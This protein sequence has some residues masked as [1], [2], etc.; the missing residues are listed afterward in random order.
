MENLYILFKNCDMR[1]IDEFFNN[2]R[3]LKDELLKY[4]FAKNDNKYSYEQNIVGDKFKV[5]IVVGEQSVMISII[6]TKTG[7]EYQI[8]FIVEASGEFVGEVRKEYE[9]LLS[10]I[11]YKCTEINVFQT[12]L[13]FDILKY[14][15][16]KYLV[17]PEFLWKKIPSGAVLRKPSSKKWFGL[18]MKINS[19]SIGILKP[20]IIE[21]LNVKLA[22]SQINALIDYQKFFPAYHMNKKSWITICCN[23]CDNI[24]NI[25]ELIDISYSLV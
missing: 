3:F 4:G 16:E 10:D 14:C 2:R 19:Q 11:R 17:F 6:D 21:I 5:Q 9:E 12:K 25:L 23:N 18:L 20:E 22:P 13:A 8:P 1:N 24:G 15:E 7:D